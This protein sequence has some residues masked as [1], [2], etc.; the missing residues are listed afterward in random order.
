MISSSESKKK[1]ILKNSLTSLRAPVIVSAGDQRSVLPAPRHRRLGEPPRLAPQLD[2]RALGH[3]GVVR[4]LVVEDVGGF[5][6]AQHA[7]LKR[8]NGVTERKRV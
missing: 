6:H 4:G 1:T 2:A 7:D 8:N 5:D 3:D